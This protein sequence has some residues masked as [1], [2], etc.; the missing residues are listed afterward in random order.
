MR[1]KNSHNIVRRKIY[2]EDKD[3][4]QGQKESQDSKKGNLDLEKI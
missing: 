3:R 1:F 2:S 4:H